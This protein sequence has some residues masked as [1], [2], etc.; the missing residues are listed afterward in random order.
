MCGKAISSR[1][2]YSSDSPPLSTFSDWSAREHLHCAMIQRVRVF[3]TR[4]MTRGYLFEC[5]FVVPTFVL[6]DSCLFYDG[7]SVSC[8]SC[9]DIARPVRYLMSRCIIKTSNSCRTRCLCEECDIRLM[10]SCHCKGINNVLWQCTV[11]AGLILI[12]Y[13]GSDI[14]DEMVLYD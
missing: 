7:E 8:L 11:M 2:D 9:Y 14:I 13:L 6:M 4:K 1:G 5:F 3:F 10:F 12:W